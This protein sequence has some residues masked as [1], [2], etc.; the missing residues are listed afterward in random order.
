MKRSGR[1]RKQPFDKLPHDSLHVWIMAEQAYC[2][3]R[4]AL[5]LE[6]PST[7]RISLPPEPEEK[8]GSPQII[9]QQIE[10]EGSI[11]RGTA[12]HLKVE[13]SAI[14]ISLPQAEKMIEKGK[15]FCMPEY[16][17][18][19]SY[20]NLPI[21]GRADAVCFHG[22]RAS[23][24]VEI[25]VT[26]SRELHPDHEA[27]LRLY[28]YLLEQNGFDINDLILCCVFI[29]TRHAQAIPTPKTLSTIWENA[30]KLISSPKWWGK[31]QLRRGIEAKL[32]VFKY[33]PQKAREELD[34]WTQF[35]LG[36]RPAKPTKKPQKC[37]SC[38]YNAVKRCPDALVPFHSKES[39]E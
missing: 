9:P 11:K 23:C 22:R 17:L 13:R 37:A 2:E 8:T 36:E 31:I 20:R 16:S 19:G 12:F 32:R 39:T 18:T 30:E 29:P 33:K 25:K 14:P 38:L 10:R 26:D 28:G 5:W 3:K 4:V 34:F 15:S 35:W 7:D 27:Q 21:I 1:Q 6:N 24:V